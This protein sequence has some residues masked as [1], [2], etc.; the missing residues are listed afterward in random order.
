[1]RNTLIYGATN[2]VYTGL[3][4]ILLPFLISAL[5]PEDY[6]IV[7]LFRSFSL[8][9]VPLL[10]L[11]AV[12]SIGRFYFDLPEKDFK[13]F[14]TS[15]QVFQFCTM[16]AAILVISF[17]S[18]FLAPEDTI[19]LYLAVL[20]FFF[21][22]VTESLLTVYRVKEEAIKYLYLRTA[23]IVLELMLMA[24]V[25]WVFHTNDWMLRVFP[26]VIASIGI[27]GVSLVLFK[28]EGYRIS[29]S[30]ELISKA[31]TYSAPLVVHMLS[32]YVL[33]IGDRFIIKV[34]LPAEALG[35]YAAAYQSGMAIS[36]FY[37]SFNL[38][39]TPTFFK[40][41]EEKRYREI[42]RVR[43]M[44]YVSLC[45]LG[46]IVAFLWFIVFPLIDT[47]GKYNVS[48]EVVLLVLVSY[49]ILSFYKFEANYFL[50]TKETKKLSVYTMI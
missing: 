11:S 30:K 9:L 48:M 41:M 27:G 43:K 20:Y 42:S 45:T 1:A 36:F 26:I 10:G 31:L 3:P 16:V 14:V 34:F 18:T 8:V 24:I 46:I 38:A 29:F 21:N 7:E 28:A 17:I 32:G 33:N 44:V 22:Q 40:W 12:Q 6:G 50:Y 5:T 13:T 2:A 49:I 15:I 4:L 19:L 25:Y 39:W 35:N 37:T 47:E 23:N